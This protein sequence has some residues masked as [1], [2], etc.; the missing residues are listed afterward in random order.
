MAL[1]PNNPVF[2]S[3]FA[4][5]CSHAGANNAHDVMNASSPFRVP[6]FGRF[7]KTRASRPFAIRG[8]RGV[9]AH[10]RMFEHVSIGTIPK[11]TSDGL[12]E[13]NGIPANVR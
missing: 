7:T 4:R 1:T 9:A 8:K 10:D 5:S 2:G 13:I 6:S 3:K 11:R 12:D